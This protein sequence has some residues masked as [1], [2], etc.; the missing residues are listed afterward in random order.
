[1][2]SH[3]ECRAPRWPPAP[4]TVSSLAAGNHNLSGAHHSAPSTY[5]TAL[6]SPPM[7]CSKM[8]G[9]RK[10][11]ASARQRQHE[12]S[13]KSKPI[14]L[15]CNL[16]QWTRVLEYT[17][18][19]QYSI[20]ERPAKGTASSAD[21]LDPLHLAWRDQPVWRT[22]GTR[23]ENRRED[24]MM[25]WEHDLAIVRRELIHCRCR[26]GDLL[27]DSVG[28]QWEAHRWVLQCCVQPTTSSPRRETNV[29]Q[30]K[31]TA[32]SSKTNTPFPA[33]RSTSGQTG[34]RAEGEK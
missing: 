14:A 16:S 7:R 24:S 11:A 29:A 1:M 22:T 9:N 15:Y 6:R 12:P 23:S 31:P 34:G 17:R 8:C 25:P 10:K 4:S 13:I 19:L 27:G 5:C 33:L 26:D 32:L 18:N 3:E 30:N 28:S 2:L 21:A 20:M